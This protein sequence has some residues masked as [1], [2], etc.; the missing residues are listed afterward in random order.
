[1]D[2]FGITDRGIVP[3][4]VFD[5]ERVGGSVSHAA[6]DLAVELGCSSIA[7]VGQDLAYSKDG[8]NYSRHAELGDTLQDQAKVHM[9]VYGN[10]VEEGWDGDP[11]ISN[12]TYLSFGQAFEIF[13]RELNEKI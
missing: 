4:D 6:F 7:L 12:N 8:A 11:V 5:Y 13:A 9:K 10:D 1:M 3:I 2:V